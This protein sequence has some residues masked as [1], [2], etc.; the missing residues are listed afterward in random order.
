MFFQCF[1]EWLNDELGTFSGKPF[2][3]QVR[4]IFTDSAFERL[5]GKPGALDATE[6]S[7]LGGA[8]IV[9]IKTRDRERLEDVEFDEFHG[10]LE[11]MG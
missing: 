4:S 1:S 8:D 9:A 3:Q 6:D 5:A 11:N 10:V 2:R 7:R